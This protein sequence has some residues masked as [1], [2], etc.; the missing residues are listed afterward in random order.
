VVLLA[1]VARRLWVGDRRLRAGGL[2]I[3]FLVLSA[4]FLVTSMSTYSM[5]AHLCLNLLWLWLYLR[6]DTHSLAALPWVGVLALGLHNPVP[7]A[8]FAAPFLLRLVRDRRFAYVA[9]CAAIYLAGSIAWYQWLSF[10]HTDLPA[11]TAAAAAATG[12]SLAGYL[13]NFKAPGLFAWFVQ[14]M[15][16]AL[17]FAWQTPA[18]AIF[19]PLGFM[20]WRRLGAVERDLAAGL[21]ITCGFYALFNATQGHGWGY[22][23]LYAALGNAMLLAGRGADDVWRAGREALVSRLVVA[24]AAI[25]LVAQLPLRGVQTERFVRPYAAALE[26]IQSRPAAV[27]TVDPFSAWYG[28][29]LIRNDPL[30]AATPKVVGVWPI[31]G[32]VPG[33]GLYPT[34]AR[35]QVYV[36]TAEELAR[37][38]LPVFKQTRR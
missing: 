24:S 26:Y 37:F 18:L 3:L 38:G 27:V 20:A 33:P 5:S 12:T 31:N 15:N 23:Y 21:L 34:A 22:R 16:V 13:T 32:W 2:A 28:R 35:G 17:F 30:F 25:T 11:T 1:A 7:H 9:Y 6:G 10:V 4:Q 36:V 14:G 8:L 19:L 29:D